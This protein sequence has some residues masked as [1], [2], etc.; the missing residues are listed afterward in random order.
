MEDQEQPHKLS[1]VIRV[2][3]A[4]SWDFYLSQAKNQACPV[5]VHFTA[6]WCIPSVAMN[7][8][9]EE[10][11]SIYQDVLFLTV[12]VDEL[13]EVASR[14]DVKAMPTFLMMRDGNVMDKLV[15]ANPEEIKKRVNGFVQS[16][17]VDMT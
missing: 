11:A 8:C 4:D 16:S 3:S 1:R 10:L 12:D 5:V 2:D 9:F 7:P 17:R 15:G 6:S 14:L 13:K